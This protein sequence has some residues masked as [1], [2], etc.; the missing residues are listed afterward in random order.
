MSRGYLENNVEENGKVIYIGNKNVKRSSE[1]WVGPIC[2]EEELSLSPKRALVH[3][4]QKLIA[5]Y[6]KTRE[7]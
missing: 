3:P 6:E 4:P 7:R 5:K 2:R 1:L